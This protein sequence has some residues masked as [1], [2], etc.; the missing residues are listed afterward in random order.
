MS[1][2]NNNDCLEFLIN[3]VLKHIKHFQ[4][5]FQQKKNYTGFSITYNENVLYAFLSLLDYEQLL[6]LSTLT[7]FINEKKKINSLNQIRYKSSFICK[8]QHFP[9]FLR[10]DYIH[11]ICS[12][13]SSISAVLSFAIMC[14]LRFR[15]R[16]TR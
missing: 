6:L 15:L 5:N 9:A 2:F 12:S 16:R 10:P 8:H 7:L 13:S 4:C 14:S 11:A 3:D 1:K